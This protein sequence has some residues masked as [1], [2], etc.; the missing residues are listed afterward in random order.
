MDYRIFTRKAEENIAAAECEYNY[1]RYNASANRAYYAMFHI[2]VAALSYHQILPPRREWEHG[3]VQ[4]TFNERLIRRKKVYPAKLLPDLMVAM[5]IRETADYRET[6]VSK[7]VC[8]RL[9]RRAQDFV[10][11]VKEKLEEE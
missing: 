8:R 6:M 11:I 3:W 9:L 2:A 1:G 10:R 7:K 4:A 5:T